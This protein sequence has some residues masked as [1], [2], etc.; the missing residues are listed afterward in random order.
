M[1]RNNKA[2]EL[3]ER[4]FATSRNHQEAVLRNL[5]RKAERATHLE[6]TMLAVIER[7]LTDDMGI[8]EFTR[9]GGD[10]I[11]EVCNVRLYDHP[12]LPRNTDLTFG[13]DGEIYKL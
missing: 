3:V 6:Q 4:F 8:I 10:V 7:L 13:C 2:D 5:A 11:C 9:A 12:R 1:S